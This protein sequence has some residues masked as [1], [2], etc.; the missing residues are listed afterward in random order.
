[1]ET[2]LS[3][4]VVR[5]TQGDRLALGR[6]LLF[7]DLRLRRRIERRISADLRPALAVEDVLQETYAAAHRHV[8]ELEPRGEGAFYAWLAMIADRKL[9]DAGKARRAAKRTPPAGRRVEHDRTTSFLGLARLVDERGHSPSGQVARR[10]AVQALQVA[11]AT[12]PEA[13]RQVVWMCHIEGQSVREI[14]AALG[15][16][17]RAVNQLCYRGLLKLREQMGHRSRFLSDS[18]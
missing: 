17:E 10:E 8:S 6:L 12:L 14:A 4:L 2:A 1:M 7:Y 16:T 5:A 18:R 15:R 13:L 11:V 9:L 3:E